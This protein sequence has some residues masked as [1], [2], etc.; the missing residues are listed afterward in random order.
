MTP[1]YI[2][3][4]RCTRKSN[5]RSRGPR[6]RLKTRRKGGGLPNWAG[7]PNTG[8][9]ASYVKGKGCPVTYSAKSAARA[10]VSSWP[11]V[12]SG[13]RRRTSKKGRKAGR[14]AG[15]G[16]GA[17]SGGGKRERG[18]RGDR[19][20]ST[21]PGD[22]PPPPPPARARPGTS[23]TTLVLGCTGDVKGI[24]LLTWCSTGQLVDSPNKRPKR[25][26]G[27]GNVI[28]SNVPWAPTYGT[29]GPLPKGMSA[30]A[31]PPPYVVTN[32]CLPNRF[33]RGR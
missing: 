18:E 8:S 30:L 10:E 19:G 15:S 31:T 28:G 16:R 26:G 24:D 5:A 3:M 27:Q 33:T 17:S 14:I 20:N 1:I 29:P 21:D 9:T 12:A 6:R 4:G 22:R 32:H 25:G 11:Y 2:H 7:R 23:R 13:G